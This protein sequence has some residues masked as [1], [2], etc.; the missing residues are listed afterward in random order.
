MKVPAMPADANAAG[1]IFGGWLMSNIDIAGSIPAGLRARGR[2]VTVAVNEMR[3]I[4]PVYIG[5]LVSLYAEVIKVGRTSIQVR[6]EAWAERDVAAPKRVQVASSLI[7][8]VAVSASGQPVPVPE[9]GP[10]PRS[11]S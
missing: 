11:Q 10:D 8:Y 1:D 2:V 6:V 9:S 4:Q 3:F 7:T 5:D